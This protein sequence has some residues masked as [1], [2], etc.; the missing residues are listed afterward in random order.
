[1][2]NN[3]RKNAVYYL[4]KFSKLIRKLLMPSKEKETS[5]NDELETMKLYM[6][7]ANIRFSNK[8]AFNIDGHASIN[9]EVTKVPSLVL[10]PFLENALWHGLS[11]KSENKKIDLNVIKNSSGHITVEIIDNGIGRI[12]SRKINNMKKLK[13]KSVGI[14]ITKARLANFSEAFLNSY[15]L[16]IED[17]YDHETPSGTKIILPIPMK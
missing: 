7:I 9:T 1:M 3:E 13:L 2:I 15:S 16:E 6:T 5:L 11:S 8:I 14:A 12:A 10:Q 17:L 4:N